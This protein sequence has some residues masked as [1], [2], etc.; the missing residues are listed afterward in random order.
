MICIFYVHLLLLI[1]YILFSITFNVA[2]NNLL[3]KVWANKDNLATCIVST[4]FSNFEKQQIFKCTVY[5]NLQ[6]PLQ[7]SSVGLKV[8]LYQIKKL[9]SIFFNTVKAIFEKAKCMFDSKNTTFTLLSCLTVTSEYI[10]WDVYGSKRGNVLAAFKK[11][12]LFS[13]DNKV[14]LRCTRVTPGS[15]HILPL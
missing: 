10:L 2:G 8:S 14:G 6:S 12:W 15:H 13:N 7:G 5:L 1:H 3:L 11:K 9:F 4:F